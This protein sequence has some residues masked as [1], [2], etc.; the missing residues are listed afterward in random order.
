MN[1]YT[2]FKQN[3]GWHATVPTPEKKGNRQAYL[4]MVD[5]AD[6]MLNIMSDGKDKVTLAFNTEPFEDAEEIELVSSCKPFLD[7]GYY[8]M[9]EHDGKQINAE[10]WICDVSRLA[11]G[12]VPEKI[13]VRKEMTD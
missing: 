5:G 9:R 1:T 8:L 6:T 4:D 10:M 13:Y 7:G 3:G 2:F 12:A 11:F